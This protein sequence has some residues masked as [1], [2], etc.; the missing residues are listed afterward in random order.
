MKETR[1]VSQRAPIRLQRRTPSLARLDMT[2]EIGRK[3]YDEQLELLQ[4]RLRE[5]ALAYRAQG[6][7]GVIAFQ[8]WDAAG[9]GGAIRRMSW[10]LDPRGFK[11]WT[12][13]APT[14]DEQGHHYLYRFWKR[15]PRPGQLAIFDRSWYGRVLVERVEGLA[16]EAEWRRAYAEINEFER[17]L[18]DDG[19]RVA[20]IFLHITPEE[21]LARFRDRF[22][23]P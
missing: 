14:P 18:D 19:V 23:D 21:Q 1:R 20:K 9:K 12:I 15:L 17:M 10:P 22:N 3:E 6:R 8:G 13:A 16:A 2:K 5:V 7:R 4:T 11:V